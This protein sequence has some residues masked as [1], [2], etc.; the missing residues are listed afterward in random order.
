MYTNV[1]RVFHK[2]SAI[3]KLTHSAY[4]VHLADQLAIVSTPL[5]AKFAFNASSQTIGILVALQSLAYL[6][7][8]IPFGYIVDTKP[9]KAVA[10]FAS[11]I[12]VA[13]FT[14]VSLSVLSSNIYW[15]AF[16][17]FISSFGAVLFVIASLSIIARSVELSLLP[18]ANSNLEIP[19][20]ASAFIV[21]LLIGFIASEVTT[22]YLFFI[23]VLGSLYAFIA[24]MQLPNYSVTSLKSGNVTK[25]IGVGGRFILKHPILAPIALC[26]LF[27]NM[28]FSALLVVSLPLFVDVYKIHASNFAT[29]LSFF[30]L[31]MICGTW[32][33]GRYSASLRPGLILIA[34]PA[35]SL[36]A[37]I[38]L[39]VGTKS[40]SKTIVYISFFLVGFGPSMWL[41]V[42]NS[43][44]QLVTPQH[45]LGQVSAVIQTAIYGV[46]PA[47][48]LLGGTITGFASPVVGL[49]VVITLFG[50]SF[51]TAY[52]SRLRTVQSYRELVLP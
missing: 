25:S 5:V 29:A 26:S 6:I 43:V 42:Q 17:L 10:I 8:S 28:A 16:A 19:R 51:L 48:A 50:A 11:L 4:G 30:G 52:F 45:M 49:S 39:L 47:G 31:A 36:V 9:L 21:P 13:G 22:N 24:T 3:N 44:R 34:G 38:M 41:I 37:I 1:F 27:W 14:S 18:Q 35:S 2:M 7:G 32:L 46:R 15:F 33:I 12:A 20:A 40:D 23:A